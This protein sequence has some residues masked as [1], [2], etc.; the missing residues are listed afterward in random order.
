[1]LKWEVDQANAGGEAGN[2]YA[3]IRY[4]D[5]LLHKAEASLRQGDDAT[6]LSIVNDIRSRAGA[7]A[8]TAI[9]LDD[10]L[11]ERGFE[12][13]WEAVRRLDLIRFGKFTEAWEL[14]DAQQDHVKLLP[15]PTEAL[16]ANPNLTQNAGY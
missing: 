12:L 9:T 4:A 8:L 6:A 10:I 7:T 5:I 16:G 2:D 15:I 11:A 1:V 14:K 13:A 3:V